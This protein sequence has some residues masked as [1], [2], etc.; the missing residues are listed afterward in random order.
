M[1]MLKLSK[2]YFQP[3]FI[4]SIHISLIRYQICYIGIGTGNGQFEVKKG[5]KLISHLFAE[6]R[7]KSASLNRARLLNFVIARYLLLIRPYPIPVIIFLDQFGP[8][9][10]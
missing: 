1:Q 6:F 10:S 7:P 8:V 9:L 4:L 5:L 2:Y 3:V